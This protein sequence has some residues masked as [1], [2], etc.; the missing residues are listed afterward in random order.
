VG[1]WS[2]TEIVKSMRDC[3]TTQIEATLDE[4]ISQAT[5]AAYPQVARQRRISA[6][7]PA[8]LALPASLASMANRQ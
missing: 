6:A 7:M 3:W 5:I 1:L 4:A 8:S 2:R